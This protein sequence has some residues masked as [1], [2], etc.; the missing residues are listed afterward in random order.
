MYVVIIYYLIDDNIIKFHISYNIFISYISLCLVKIWWNDKVLFRYFL[1][2]IN[3]ETWSWKIIV[4]QSSYFLIHNCIEIYL[5]NSLVLIHQLLHDKW[6]SFAA[7]KVLSN[8][9]SDL[10]LYGLRELFSV[11]CA[12]ERIEVVLGAPYITFT[13]H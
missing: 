4:R 13:F 2:C 10:L 8:I 12:T 7:A 3:Y 5:I 6:N 1:V 11:Q 9:N